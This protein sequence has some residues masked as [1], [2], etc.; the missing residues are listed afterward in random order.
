VREQ[1]PECHV[2]PMSFGPDLLVDE[3]ALQA[4]VEGGSIQFPPSYGQRGR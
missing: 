2:I 3:A 4:F 1:L